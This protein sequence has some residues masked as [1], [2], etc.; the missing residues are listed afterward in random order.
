MKKVGDGFQLSASDLVGFLNCR[1]LTSLDRKVA[2]G[3]LP[4][5]GSFNPTLQAL[6]DRG[7]A[8]EAQFVAHL[9][10]RGL[11]VVVIDGVDV[12]PTAVAQT[13]AAMQA[14]RP[15]IVQGA[16]MHAGW[17]GRADVLRRVDRPSGL[18]A[19]SYEVTD[20]K[21]ARETKAG[22]ILQLCLYS[23]LV[24]Q[25]QGC[26]PEYM[27]VVSP[28]TEFTPQQYRY[29]DFAAFYRKAKRGLAAL[30]TTPE[31]AV[32]PDPKPYCEICRWEAACDRRRRD[33]D[34]LCLVAGITRLQSDELKRQGIPTTSALAQM[35]VPLAWKPGRGTAPSYERVREQARV[36]VEDRL[37][38][39]RR[40]EL[41]PVEAGCGFCLL[42]DPSDGDVFF[43]VE[44][45]PYVGEDGLEYLFGFV[46]NKHGNLAYR[47]EWAF[48]RI[49]EKHAFEAF[50]DFIMERRARYPDLHIYHYAPY[51]PAALK[52]LMGRYATREDA[53]DQLLR[54]GVFVDLYAVVRRS[55]RASVE[56]YSLK[57]LEP[58]YGFEREVALPDAN[59]ALFCVQT[60]LERGDAMA[61][62]DDAAK[63]VQNY[64]R[65]DCRS[66][67]Q[68]RAW[69]ETLRRGL[70]D[71]GTGVPR[72]ASGDGAAPETVSDW[73][74]K[75]N[76]LVEKLTAGVPVDPTLRTSE[77]HARWVLAHILDWHRREKKATW[78]E[79]YRLSALSAEDLLDERAG[80]AGLRFVATVGGSPRAPVQRYSFPSQDTDLRDGDELRSAGGTRYGR[81]H[82]MTSSGQAIDIKKRQDTADQ[83]AEAIFAHN[84][85]DDQVCADALV[86]IG[87]YV[88]RHGMGGH[89][90]YEAARA[91]LM[92]EPPAMT[93]EPLRCEGE[94]MLDEALRLC[95]RLSRGVLPIQGP[96]GAGK[97]FTGAH[98][99]CA[100]VERGKKVGIT[101]NSHKVIRNLIDR[102]L[103]IANQEG[104]LV[105]CCHK[106]DDDDAPRDGLTFVKKPERLLQAMATE[107]Q[108]G[109][110]TAW[111]W[112]R[113]DAFNAVDVLFVD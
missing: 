9:R 39:E 104:I 35:P 57:R 103:E 33:D 42:P 108:V 14:G 26:E 97:T 34:H 94:S 66:A 105:R 60:N 70:V 106:T 93:G 30:L 86:R 16:L 40:F 28:W 109:G 45:D 49:D 48:S 71:A 73:T 25:I 67:E 24:A 88:A 6:R 72:P 8:H 54:A 78:W 101:A 2:D 96:P 32:Y 68:L 65:D 98:M 36:Q 82:A 87:E 111:L 91:L 51:E 61:V 41:Q 55:V 85:V 58:F 89:G 20:T 27:D 12:S 37:S 79:R 90:N 43:D 18:G 38:G 21:L 13:I 76:E 69:L 47:A 63:T 22:T 31:T 102:V 46:F 15:V 17:G 99:I 50:I 100:L 62:P 1:Y 4:K 44:G 5:P 107:C 19:W 29:H 81:V 75:I 23:E 80:L 112:S 84:E 95:E 3:T 77:Q 59:A 74:V 110:G 10:E 53:V 56:S 64:N 113:S 52:R 11:D 7:A 83:H 92:K